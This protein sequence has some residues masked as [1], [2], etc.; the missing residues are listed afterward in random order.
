MKRR[1][2]LLLEWFILFVAL[3]LL[4]Y[5]VRI[6]IAFLVVPLIILATFAP[7][8]YLILDKDFSNKNFLRT[9]NIPVHLRNIF[10]TFVIPAALATLWTYLAFRNRFMFFPRENPVLW[11]IVLL[12]YPVLAAFPQEIIFRGFFFHRYGILFPHP[13]LMIL[14]NGF[15]FG[16]AH[17]LYG[18]WIAPILSLFGGFLFAYRYMRSHSLFIVGIEHGLWGDF[19]FTVGLGWYFYSGSIGP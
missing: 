4:L 5:F 10:L 7:L 14:V 15:C 11:V 8:A 6:Q 1:I 13:L 18:N 19:L 2:F 3:P 9:E 16:W 12:L 17:L